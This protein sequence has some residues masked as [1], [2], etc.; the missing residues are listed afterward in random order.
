MYGACLRTTG[1]T[2]RSSDTARRVGVVNC[3]TGSGKLALRCAR[4]APEWSGRRVSIIRNEENIRVG[5]IWDLLPTHTP[6]ICLQNTLNNNHQIKYTQPSH[7]FSIH[8]GYLSGQSSEAAAHIV[9][10]RLLHPFANVVAVSF[11]HRNDQYLRQRRKHNRQHVHVVR[12]LIGLR[13]AQRSLREHIAEA[14]QTSVVAHYAK[15]GKLL[16]N[17]KH[18]QFKY[19]LIHTFETQGKTTYR[20]F[21]LLSVFKKNTETEMQLLSIAYQLRTVRS[22]S[23]PRRE[24]VLVFFCASTLWVM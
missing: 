3:F 1:L 12:R 24:F 8:A 10:L 18:I 13:Y 4:D 6:I 22:L 16:L 7:A 21:N 19:I 9:R 15:Q 11:V 14:Q 2:C 23:F 17:Q 5:L 20:S